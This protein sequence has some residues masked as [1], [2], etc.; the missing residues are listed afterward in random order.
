MSTKL[1]L[2]F[3]FTATK[4]YVSERVLAR[5]IAI[6]ENPLGKILLRK[7]TRYYWS[8]PLSIKWHARRNLS[9]DF[10]SFASDI[11]QNTKDLDPEIII[12]IGCGAGDLVYQ[13]SKKFINCN[14][15]GVD[16]NE[17]QIALNTTKYQNSSKLD[18]IYADIEN[19]IKD[20]D[21]NGNILIASQNT[22]DYFTKDRLN[23]IFSLISSR[24]TNV[25]IVVSAIKKNLTIKD[26]VLSEHTWKVYN[27]NYESLLNQAGYKTTK[28]YDDSRPDV[29]LVLGSKS[30]L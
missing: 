17:T 18:F 24:I 19:Y 16:I 10:E 13:L 28:F 11:Y 30:A 21:F 1:K 22:L 8:H 15:V 23:D 3:C 20:N 9:S 12:E 29:A 6:K 2:P 14:I 25:T 4:N 27:H 7:M 26:S 5:L